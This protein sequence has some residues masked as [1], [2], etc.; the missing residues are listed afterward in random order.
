MSQVL[1]LSFNIDLSQ[2][3]DELIKSI[4][5]IVE[6]NENSFMPRI[7]KVCSQYDMRAEVSEGSLAVEEVN[8]G[9]L[10]SELVSGNVCVTYDWSSYYG[11]K[12]MCGEDRV[13][14]AWDFSISS[15]KLLI[16]LAIPEERVDE[17]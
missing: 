15:G 9:E 4:T 13:D 12:D 8:L 6:E 3:E 10:S 17:I 1:K 2:N 14:D 7:A 16:D 11:C 5:E